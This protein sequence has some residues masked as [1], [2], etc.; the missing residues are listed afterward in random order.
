MFLD[1]IRIKTQPYI[2]V[3][4]LTPFDVSTPAGRSEERLRRVVLSTGTSVLARVITAFTALISV[5]LTIHYLGTERYGLW[6]TVS[7]VIT[8]LGF[9][10]LGMGS[11]LVN[12]VAEANGHNDRQVAQQAVSSTFFFLSA[13]AVLVL[14]T[15]FMLYSFIS[16][17]RIFN[18]TSDLAARESG[19]AMAVFILCFALSLPLGVAQRVQM[20]YQEGFLSSLWQCAGSVLGLLALLV[21]VRVNAGL[22]WLV[23]AL[24]GAPVLA[25]GL[26]W[27]V[28]FGK[29][30]MWLMPAIHRFLWSAGKAI[31]SNGLLFFVL[32]VLYLVGIAS[33]NLIIAQVLG[34]EAV[35]SYAVTQKLFTALQF[36]SFVSYA[37]WPAFGEALARSDYVWAQRTYNRSLWLG[38]GMGVATI[39]PLLLFG[40]RIIT[41]WAGAAVVPSGMLLVGSAGWFLVSSFGAATSPL[42]YSRA[43]LLRKQVGFHALATFFSLGLKV[44]FAHLWQASGVIWGGVVGYGIFFVIPTLFVAKAALAKPLHVAQQT[45]NLPSDHP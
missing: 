37:L 16:W 28:E 40:Q 29:R 21:A 3:I 30:R 27:L 33:D 34:A 32:S 42:L 36:F 38:M 10:D 2:S 19:P 5:P 25:A 35:A 45:A 8:L 4:R 24:A 12:A 14:T 20:G 11:G 9:A 23:L 13:I 26:N 17:P 44:V 41:W 22:P 7:S 43:T 6:M 31:L 39:M 1:N 15:F 18:V